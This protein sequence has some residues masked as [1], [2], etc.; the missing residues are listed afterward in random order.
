MTAVIETRATRHTV[1]PDHVADG[2]GI[3]DRPVPRGGVRD[4]LSHDGSLTLALKSRASH[5]LRYLA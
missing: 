2:K 5:P 3:I 1:L 4:D